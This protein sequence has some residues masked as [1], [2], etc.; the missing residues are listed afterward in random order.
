[1]RQI[2]DIPYHTLLARAR[3]GALTE[4]DLSIL[5]SK[6]IT[7]LASP[8][9]EDATAVTKMN[10]LRHVV[11]RM[12]IQ[13]FVRARHQRVYIFPAIH[14]RTRSSDPKNLGFQMTCLVF[15]SKT[16]RSHFLDFFFIL[17]PRLQ[18]Y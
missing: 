16:P 11:N 7:S 15:L 17:L 1:M 18:W 12:Q 9:L 2:N 6:A 8:H 5:N 3:T 14:T 10:A 13:R 4:D